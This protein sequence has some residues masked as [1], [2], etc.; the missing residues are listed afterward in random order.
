MSHDENLEELE[1]DS[2]INLAQ[3]QEYDE[4]DIAGSERDLVSPVS[5]ILF[6]RTVIGTHKLK[7]STLPLGSPRSPTPSRSSQPLRK[8]SSANLRLNLLSRGRNLP[9]EKTD[10]KV[11]LAQ[12]QECN[13]SNNA[14]SNRDIVVPIC[15][16]LV[17]RRAVDIDK[18]ETAPI[19][20]L[21]G[22]DSSN[23]NN[24]NSNANKNN[25]LING[26]VVSV[27][28]RGSTDSSNDISRMGLTVPPQKASNCGEG[29]RALMERRFAKEENRRTGFQRR[30]SD[31]F[32]ICMM[33]KSSK[34]KSQYIC[35]EPL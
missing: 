35:S 10:N 21:E 17:S 30:G 14:D 7:A 27:I 25:H 13:A 19:V 15:Q 20:V 22:A 28:N 26:E 29:C 23:N 1:H 32:N 5:Q 31:A 2:D 12:L 34:L 9:W 24:S 33:Y 18:P 8:T 16:M 11:N 4:S 6:S 3:P